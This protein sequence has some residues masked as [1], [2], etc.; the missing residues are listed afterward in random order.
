MIEG[1]EFPL[2]VGSAPDLRAGRSGLDKGT[3]AA[4]HLGLERAGSAAR[5]PDSLRAAAPCQVRCSVRGKVGASA[6]L[7]A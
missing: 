7:S 4:A 3:L 2:I 5:S 1:G 6:G